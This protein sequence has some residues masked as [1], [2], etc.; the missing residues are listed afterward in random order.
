MYKIIFTILILLTTV[1]SVCI[2]IIKPQMHKSV[3]VYNSDYTIVQPKEIQV[4]HKEVPIMEQPASSEPKKTVFEQ[5]NFVQTQE[6]TL[7]QPKIKIE[8]KPVTTQTNPIKQ[9]TAVQVQNNSIKTTPAKTAVTNTQNTKTT[10]S[11][12]IDLQKIIQ[13]NNDIQATKVETPKNTVTPVQTKTQAQI[14]KVSAPAPIQTVKTTSN[15][16]TETPTKVLT[17]KEEEIAWNVWRSNLNNKIMQDTNFPKVPA[18]TIFRY[19]FNVD[20]FGKITNVQTWSE[21]NPQYTPYA[22]QYMAPV[23]RNLQ[24]RQILT[25]PQGSA[26]TSVLAWGAWKISERTIY[27]TPDNYDDLE[28]VKR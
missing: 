10:A 1:L 9:S 23:I 4:E 18:G 22:I 2:C 20:K 24:G 3:F 5:Q 7:T 14:A 16:K 8:T 11:P 12:Q 25:F 13:N 6:I 17:E 27:S 28:K 26:R 19:Q 21:N 15:E